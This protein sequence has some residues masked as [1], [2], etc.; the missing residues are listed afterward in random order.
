[1]V[2][3]A[4]LLQLF[5]NTT[6][7][8]FTPGGV[9]VLE[10]WPFLLEPLISVTELAIYTQESRSIRILRNLPGVAESGEV[11]LVDGILQY[12]RLTGNHAR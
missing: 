7:S 5:N 8:L 2:S 6:E 1:M 12:H 4:G 3:P 11:C 10:V 9:N